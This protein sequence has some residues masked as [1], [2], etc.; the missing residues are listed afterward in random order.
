[1]IPTNSTYI[2]LV[3]KITNLSTIS[4]Y[5]SISCYST[6]YKC[7]SNLLA[8]KLKPTLPHIIDQAQS[9]FMLGRQ[10]DDSILLV[11]ELLNGYHRQTFSPRCALK[12]DL[13]RAFISVSWDF[14]FD[15]LKLFGFQH[16]LTTESK[17]VFLL[18]HSPFPSMGNLMATSAV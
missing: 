17:L 6:I 9:A 3:P 12:I 5:T 15:S 18:P 13:K 1:M 11:Q 7:I 16:C 4:D 2:S 14:L 10:I 8:N